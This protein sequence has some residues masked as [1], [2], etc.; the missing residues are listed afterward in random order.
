MHCCEKKIYETSPR[1]Q[2]YVPNLGR[3]KMT[4]QSVN[5]ACFGK[6]D[7]VNNQ[8]ENGTCSSA[9]KGK[10]KANRRFFTQRGL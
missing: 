6:E 1:I 7:R 2:L 4:K 10:K 9:A 8:K 5:A 3:K